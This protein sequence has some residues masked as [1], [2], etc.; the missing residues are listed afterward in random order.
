MNADMVKKYVKD[1]DRLLKECREFKGK[2]MLFECEA[3][4]I[5]I[6]GIIYKY[7]NL[8]GILIKDEKKGELDAIAYL[9]PSAKN[10]IHIEFELYSSNFVD[11]GHD[12]NKCDLIVCWQHDWKEC[13]NNIDVLEL[14]QFWDKANR[15]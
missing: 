8:L 3:M 1:L 5:F 13:P 14:E 9:D 4:V 6:F 12:P 2:D 11:H 15:S 7:F 10:E